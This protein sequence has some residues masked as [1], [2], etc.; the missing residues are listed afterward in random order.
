[1]FLYAVETGEQVIEN[2]INY[3]EVDVG[4]KLFGSFKAAAMAADAYQLTPDVGIKKL[5]VKDYFYDPHVYGDKKVN[6]NELIL[7][8][9]IGTIK[10]VNQFDGIY[11]LIRPKRFRIV[12]TYKN[13]N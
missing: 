13:A 1:M 10:Y 8:G 5:L 6:R 12:E 11:K 3:L 2:G 7:Y 9:F 4:E